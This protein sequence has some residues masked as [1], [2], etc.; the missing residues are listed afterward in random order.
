LPLTR[1]VTTALAAPMILLL[2]LSYLPEIRRAYEDAH[3]FSFLGN[4]R[5]DSDLLL[6]HLVPALTEMCQKRV[7]AIFVFPGRMDW[8]SHISG[9]EAYDAPLTHSLLLSLFNT[10][11]PRHDGAAVIEG[12]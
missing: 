12:N 11:S 3:L 7:G 8:K 6:T 5:K 10:L 1:I 9:G 4:H 2:L